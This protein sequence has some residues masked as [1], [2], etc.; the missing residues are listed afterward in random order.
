MSDG[1]QHGQPGSAAALQLALVTSMATGGLA[2]FNY[3]ELTVMQEAG[4]DVDLFV[5]KF[6][7]G[8]YMPTA[9]TKVYSVNLAKVL[10]S[11]VVGMMG[12]PR[13]YFALLARVSYL[14]ESVAR[15]CL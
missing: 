7:T 10:L 8:P 6:R 3:R 15:K 5:T 13:N 11:Q 9:D 14:R 1:E 12:Q 2:G 4:A